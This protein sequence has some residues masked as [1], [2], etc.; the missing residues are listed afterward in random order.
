MNMPGFTGEASLYKTSR[1]YYNAGNLTQTDGVYPAIITMIDMVRVPVV[2]Y[3]EL[4]EVHHPWTTENREY[5]ATLCCH[6]CWQG[7]RRECSY[8]F[9]GRPDRQ[10]VNSC[11][12][13]LCTPNCKAWHWTADGT[14]GGC[15]DLLGL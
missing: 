4:T 10:C 15:R 12:D 7:C 8:P 14:L 11:L 1:Q 9:G 2:Y 5:L 3:P 6:K 13:S